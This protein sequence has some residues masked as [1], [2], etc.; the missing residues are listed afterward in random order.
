MKLSNN[1]GWLLEKA[2]QEDS[3]VVTAISP[4]LINPLSGLSGLV[5]EKERQIKEYEAAL[6]RIVNLCQGIDEDETSWMHAII[7]IEDEA[8][9]LLSKYNKSRQEVS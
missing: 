3:Q 4:Y 1:R 7:G 2:K 6:N 5:E 8:K 9:H